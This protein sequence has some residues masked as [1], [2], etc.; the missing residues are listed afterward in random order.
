MYDAKADGAPVLAI[1]GQVSSDE[2]GRD[3]FRR[4]VLNECLRMWLSLISR[5]IR[6]KPCLTFES[7]DP[8][9][10]QPKGAAVLSVSDDLFAER[11]S[12]RRFIRLRFISKAILNRRKAS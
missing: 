5:C 7:G 2:I 12:G 4:S 8:Y 1:T 6:L 9:R 10:I 11:L 3:Y